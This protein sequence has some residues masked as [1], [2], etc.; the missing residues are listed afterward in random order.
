MIVLC[1]AIVTTVA[2]S[3]MF[4]SE[5]FFVNTIGVLMF[6]LYLGYTYYFIS[7]EAIN[8]VEEQPVGAK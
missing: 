3:A 5:I 4:L 8:K 2:S 7:E 6:W 1:L